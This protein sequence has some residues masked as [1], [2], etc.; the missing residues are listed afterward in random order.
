MRLRRSAATSGLRRRI[1]PVRQRRS[2]VTLISSRPSAS[3]SGVWR[4][5]SRVWSRWKRRRCCSSAVGRLASVGWAVRTGSTTTCARPAAISSGLRPACRRRWRFAPHRPGSEAMPAAFSRARR[6]CAETFS[7]IRLS[8]WNAVAYTCPSRAG[9]SV[10]SVGVCSVPVQGTNCA[11]FSSPSSTS[12]SRRHSITKA[13]SSSILIRP[14]SSNSAGG[15]LIVEVV[16]NQRTGS[17][18]ARS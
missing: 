5:S 9:Y 13:R 3:S 1:S 11:R 12:T 18:P 4:G 16:L 6:T 15:T 7:S 17:A 14:A 10:P 8:N 2:R